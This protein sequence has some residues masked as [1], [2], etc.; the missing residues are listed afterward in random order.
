SDEFQTRSWQKPSLN[1]TTDRE[2][3]SDTGHLMKFSMKRAMV[4]LQFESTFSP[5]SNL[6]VKLPTQNIKIVL[7]L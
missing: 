7:Y 1:S 4:H 2:N 5:F 3:V 6:F